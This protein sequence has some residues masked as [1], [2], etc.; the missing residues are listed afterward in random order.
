MIKYKRS[1]QRTIAFF[2]E[3]WIYSITGFFFNRGFRT[4]EEYNIIKEYL[5]RRT[6]FTGISR[7]HLDDT[8]DWELGKRMARERLIENYKNTLSLLLD[9]LTEYNYKKHKSLVESISVA[10]EDVK[11]CIK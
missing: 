5:D 8:F 11:N 3:P 6:K 9:M 4:K 7:C 10:S 1:G 2:T